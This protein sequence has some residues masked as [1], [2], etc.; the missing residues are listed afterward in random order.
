MQIASEPNR[1]IPTSPA[2]AVDIMW[3]ENTPITT[4]WFSTKDA[5]EA[6]EAK[7]AR[8]AHAVVVRHLRT[9]PYSAR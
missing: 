6:F 8:R 3:S 1:S 9:A 5:A 2:Y 4:R 7:I